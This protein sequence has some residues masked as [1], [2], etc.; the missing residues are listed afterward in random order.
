M[1]DS[2]RKGPSR[3]HFTQVR[4]ECGEPLRV[5]RVAEEKQRQME[6]RAANPADSVGE[7]PHILDKPRERVRLRI[8]LRGTAASVANY[9]CGYAPRLVQKS[10]RRGMVAGSARCHDGRRWGCAEG[11]ACGRA[12]PRI[13]SESLSGESN[14]ETESGPALARRVLR[15]PADVG[16]TRQRAAHLKLGPFLPVPRG[17][18]VVSAATPG[19]AKAA[20]DTARAMLARAVPGQHANRKFWRR[21]GEPNGS[22]CRKPTAVIAN[23]GQPY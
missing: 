23:S 15:A 21:G 7:A 6:I 5:D 13:A 10:R 4:A 14:L 11:A 18:T 1:E 22:D 2:A 9:T 17:K 16:G 8:N 20:H 12:G 3:Q 19:S